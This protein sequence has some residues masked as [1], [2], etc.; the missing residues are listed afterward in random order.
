MMELNQLIDRKND[1]RVLANP[2]QFVKQRIAQAAQDL[3]R[4]GDRALHVELANEAVCKFALMLYARDSDGVP[5][6]IEPRSGRI[7]VAAPWGNAGWRKWGL[8]YWEAVT[9]R[10]VLMARLS[11]PRHV[12]LFDYSPAVRRWYLNVNNYPSLDKA[13][14]YLL[15]CPVKL[16]EWRIGSS[17]NSS[18][19]SALS[20]DQIV[21]RVEIR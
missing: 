10:G 20:N 8:R 6:N 15:H 21:R 13:Q 4:A 19:G 17:W 16:D 1:I 12:P 9:L 14:A 5:A 18:T 2:S 3:N 7:Y 11:K